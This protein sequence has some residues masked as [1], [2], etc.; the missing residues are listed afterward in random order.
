MIK[1]AVL[2]LISMTISMTMITVSSG[3]FEK[4]N[5]TADSRNDGATKINISLSGSLQNPAFSPDGNYLVFTR[6]RNGY[7][8]EP[9]DIF[10]VAD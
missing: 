9:A 5:P 4:T 7:N 6:F 3:A 10:V 8:E 1:P 2:L